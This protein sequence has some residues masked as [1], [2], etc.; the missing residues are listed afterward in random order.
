MEQPNQQK[1]HEM[2]KLYTDQQAPVDFEGMTKEEYLA[3]IEGCEVAYSDEDF[4]E[5]L[6]MTAQ[7]IF[8][9]YIQ[10]GFIFEIDNNKQ[11]DTI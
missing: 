9:H 7:Q 5:F 1:E 11:K 8:D 10:T 4:P 6:G 3:D 2:K